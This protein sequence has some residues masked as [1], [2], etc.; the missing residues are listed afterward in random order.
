MSERDCE[1]EWTKAEWE[2]NLKWNRI[3]EQ[4]RNVNKHEL[5]AHKTRNEL[6]HVCQHGMIANRATFCNLLLSLTYQGVR[7]LE[8]YAVEGDIVQFVSFGS[9]SARAAAEHFDTRRI[10]SSPA[11]PLY[12]CSS[13]WLYMPAL[14]SLRVPV[15]HCR[16]VCEVRGTRC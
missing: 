5:N 2:I 7:D 12:V 9:R 6:D 4:N 8:W 13:D 14:L 1:E 16:G 10:V 15:W 3:K 11:Y